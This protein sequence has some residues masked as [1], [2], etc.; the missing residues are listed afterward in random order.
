MAETRITGS[1]IVDRD[2]NA[3]AAQRSKSG[4]QLVIIGN[5]GVLGQFQYE[6]VARDPGQQ[7][8]QPFA[9][10]GGGGNIQ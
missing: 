7:R 4:D 2:A 6:T 5:P 8:G 3:R 1:D 9:Q 10:H